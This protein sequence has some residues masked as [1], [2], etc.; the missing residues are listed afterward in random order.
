MSQ[1][2][3]LDEN[4]KQIQFFVTNPTEVP[5][6]IVVRVTAREQKQDGSE[7]T[8]ETNLVDVFPPQLIIPPNEKR[9]VRVSWKG[10]EKPQKELAFRLFAEQVPL[11]V[12]KKSDKKK[13]GIKMLLKYIAAF[14]VDPGNT[15]PKLHIA[16]FQSSKQGLKVTL[17]NQGSKHAPLLKPELIFIKGKEKI[18][19]KEQEL[20]GLLGE[21]ILAGSTR[22]FTL[23]AK[24]QITKEFSVEIKLHD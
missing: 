15:E 4:E 24:A 13:T 5:M 6:P 22:T 16:S 20:K 8:P 2:L 9:A 7:N 1:S 23:P 19:L 3:R 11:D 21:N 14:Y 18:S 12:N 17:Q 10:S